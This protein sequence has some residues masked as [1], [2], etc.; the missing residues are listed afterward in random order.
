MLVHAYNQENDMRWVAGEVR[1][2]RVGFGASE[3][4]HFIPTDTSGGVCFALSAYWIIKKANGADFWAWLPG[5]GAHVKDIKDL[6][7][8]QKAGAEHDYSRFELLKTT[9]TGAS[10]LAQQSMALMDSGQFEHAG[11]YYISI[12]GKKNGKAWGHGIAAHVVAGEC[13]YFDPNKGEYKCDSRDV[14]LGELSTLVRGYALKST[15]V[16]HCCFA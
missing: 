9:I 2:E 3:R 1:P 13:R 11:Y 12:T 4:A 15:K 10:Q 8:A 14:C 7:R 16:Y 6:M 5:P